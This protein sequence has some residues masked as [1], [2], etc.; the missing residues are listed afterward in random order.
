MSFGRRNLIG[1]AVQV[2][3]S[4]LIDYQCALLHIMPGWGTWSFPSSAPRGRKKQSDLQTH[5]GRRNSLPLCGSLCCSPFRDK[6]IENQKI[7]HL[8][9][10]NIQLRR[11][12]V[13]DKYLILEFTMSNDYYCFFPTLYSLSFILLYLL[14]S[15]YLQVIPRFSKLSTSFSI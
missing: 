12:T 9:T 15:S 2:L 6:T 7:S 11:L 3:H 1:H 10:P 13:V 8:W 4:L 14:P 5:S